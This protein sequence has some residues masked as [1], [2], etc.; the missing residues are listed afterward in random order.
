MPR[1]KRSAPARRRRS[2]S[3]VP[4]RAQPAAP[5]HPPATQPRQPGL[6]AQMA[7][8]AA[9]VAVGSAVGHTLDA[10]MTGGSGGETL[11]TYQEPA[12]Q[13]TQ[14]QPCQMEFRQF[15]EC[16]QTQND[17]SMCQGFNEVLKE[18]KLKFGVHL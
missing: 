5:A 10:A 9:G 4:A 18:C 17:I 11:P 13:Q 3:F 1:R 2:P 16:T 8:T 6:M 15:I 12:Y 14:L 7:T